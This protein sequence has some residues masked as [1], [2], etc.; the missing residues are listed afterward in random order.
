MND[1]KKFTRFAHVLVFSLL[2]CIMLLVPAVQAASED[3]TEFLK[4]AFSA[5]A[6]VIQQ[7]LEKGINI[8]HQNEMGFTALIIAA[9]YGHADI[10]NLL[11][12][13][14]ADVNLKNAGDATALIIAAKNGHADIVNALLAKGAKIDAQASDG[15][16]A[17]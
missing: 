7:M 16:T 10:V 15:T 14:N 6:E 9:Q 4:A 2:F 5:R 17:L 3:E 1:I 8:N 11:L 13:K 12:E